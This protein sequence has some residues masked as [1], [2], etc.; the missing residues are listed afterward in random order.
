MAEGGTDSHPGEEGT[1]AAKRGRGGQRLTI[2][3]T[4]KCF[5]FMTSPPSSGTAV[6]IAKRVTER[7]FPASAEAG[8]L[9]ASADGVVLAKKWFLL[10]DTTP[11][12]PSKDAVAIFF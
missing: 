7:A 1:A 5:S 2:L 11:S 9:R 4:G 8:W 10:V 6:K 3:R 12:A